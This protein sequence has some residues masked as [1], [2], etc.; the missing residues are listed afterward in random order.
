MDQTAERNAVL[1]YVATKDRQLAVYG[2]EGIHQK[3]GLAYWDFEV[4]KMISAFSKDDCAA[5]IVQCVEDIGKALQ[6]HFPYNKS[7]DKN[8]LPDDIVFGR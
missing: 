4:K 6:H 1:I 5:G 2:D 8:E 3:V 7:T